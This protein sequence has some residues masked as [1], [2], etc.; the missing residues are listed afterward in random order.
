VK[1]F[2]EAAFA[3]A[4]FAEVGADNKV[5]FPWVVAEEGEMYILDHNPLL[6]HFGE[7][8]GKVRLVVDTP[9]ASRYRNFDLSLL[10]I[11]AVPLVLVA[12]PDRVVASLGPAFH[13]L[14]QK[15]LPDVWIFEPL[16]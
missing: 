8:F 13:S 4:A 14:V 9:L 2:A 1:T 10:H 7:N 15:D 16:S 11:A 5:A 6:K 3:E 12:C